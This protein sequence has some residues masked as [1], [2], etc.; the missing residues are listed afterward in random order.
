MF[1]IECNKFR[2]IIH[3]C[4]KAQWKN[5]CALK[6]LLLII[7]VN[8]NVHE[9]YWSC[10]LV[11]CLLRALTIWATESCLHFPGEPNS[12][13]WPRHGLTFFV[14][15]FRDTLQF[16]WFCLHFVSYIDT[17]VW[18]LLNS[19]TFS[20]LPISPYFNTLF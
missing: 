13:L 5:Y 14:S 12:H 7:K 15:L 8:K 16:V 3:K 20:H 1:L 2:G 11:Y 18:S 10:P 9:A 17:T 19:L 4:L 6:L